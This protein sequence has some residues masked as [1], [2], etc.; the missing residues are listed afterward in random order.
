MPFIFSK[1]GVTIVAVI[2]GSDVFLGWGHDNLIGTSHDDQMYGYGGNDTL[3]GRSSN[4]QL[5]GGNDNELIRFKI[6]MCQKT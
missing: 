3:N 4:D 2:K 5:W 1:Q 6:L